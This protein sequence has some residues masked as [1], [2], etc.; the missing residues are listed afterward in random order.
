MMSRGEKSRVLVSLQYA[1]MSMTSPFEEI[2][3]ANWK[4]EKGRGARVD[5]LWETAP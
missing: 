2:K 5:E 1:S 3:K 4:E